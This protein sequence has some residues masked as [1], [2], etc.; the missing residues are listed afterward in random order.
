[1]PNE[2]PSTR[3]SLLDAI[4]A[5]AIVNMI[6]YHLCYNI[7][8][9]FGVW[10]DFYRHPTAI[11]WEHLIC[12]TFILISGMVVNFSRHGYR[13]G[14]I[15]SM[16][17]F[18]ITIVT[19]LVIPEQ[20]I[21]FGVLN[22]LGIS[23]IITFAIRRELSRIPPLIGTVIFFILFMLCYGIP[24]RYIGIFTHPLISLPDALYRYRPLAFLGFP[25]ERFHSADYFPLL[26]WIF[27][28]LSGFEAWRLIGKK[29]WQAAFTRRVPVLDFIGRHSLII[30]L[31]HQ[32]ILYGLCWLRFTIAAK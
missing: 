25:D 10:A 21:W 28:Y 13:R 31:A 8:C 1:M 6:V 27:L 17:G 19:V 7:F 15:V 24:H 14:V 22:L 9:V 5:V 29:G 3:Y 30:Y 23:M 26:P 11:V 4:R 32:P 18:L 2:R 16:C 12:G 20:Q